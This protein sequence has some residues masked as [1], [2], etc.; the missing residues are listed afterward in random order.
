MEMQFA[1][2]SAAKAPSVFCCF[3]LVEIRGLFKALVSNNACSALD[4]SLN[5]LLKMAW[6][7]CSR[8]FGGVSSISKASWMT[9]WRI[10]SVKVGPSP[11]PSNALATDPAKSKKTRRDM[12]GMFDSTTC[13]LNIPMVQH[14]SKSMYI[15]F[16]TI[17]MLCNVSGV[18]KTLQRGLRWVDLK[19]RLWLMHITSS[20]GDMDIYA[21]STQLG[22]GRGSEF[23][24][25]NFVEAPP[26]A[27][28]AKLRFSAS[29]QASGLPR[30][31]SDVIA[32]SIAASHSR[33][34]WR[35]PLAKVARVDMTAHISSYFK[36]QNFDPAHPAG[37]LWIGWKWFLYGWAWRIK[38]RKGWLHGSKLP[39]LPNGKLS[40]SLRSARRAACVLCFE[41][42]CAG[43]RSAFCVW[44]K[45]TARSF[46]AGPKCRA[47]ISSRILGV[48]IATPEFS[49][50]VW[51]GQYSAQISWM[52]SQTEGPLMRIKFLQKP[53]VKDPGQGDKSSSILPKHREKQKHSSVFGAGSKE[54]QV[55]LPSS[56]S[57]SAGQSHRPSLIAE[58]GTWQGTSKHGSVQS[59]LDQNLHRSICRIVWSRKF[60]KPFLSDM[61]CQKYPTHRIYKSENAVENLL[62]HARL[63]PASK[64]ELMRGSHRNGH[65]STI[66][67]QLWGHWAG[68][69]LSLRWQMQVFGSFGMGGR[70]RKLRGSEKSRTSSTQRPGQSQRLF[71]KSAGVT[72]HSP[73]GV[74]WMEKGGKLSKSQVWTRPILQTC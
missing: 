43:D 12:E 65:S 30:R 66:S 60:K 74:T 29:C 17:H 46:S 23:Q 57:H 4:P 37:F 27:P 20:V 19:L 64:P 56:S 59:D 70:K 71:C 47:S 6:A 33:M 11:E 73:S 55:K 13:F 53:S 14:L 51:G 8:S 32:S 69:R 68:W 18:P 41:C 15:Y 49:E 24:H 26:V 61:K 63:D 67:P 16:Y 36:F 58:L 72:A 3:A 38:N 45:A 2:F 31:G 5:S 39:L 52:N 50:A 34:P 25:C 35:T 7:F 10:G 9:A 22:R 1:W 28:S 21:C 42:G 44:F 54:L 48:T 62:D 40:D